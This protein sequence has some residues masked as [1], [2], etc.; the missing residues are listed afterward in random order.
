MPRRAV[1]WSQRKNR[2]SKSSHR[3]VS[4]PRRAVAWSQR[5][6][7]KIAERMCCCFSAPKGCCLVAT[8]KPRR[9]SNMDYAV[10]VPRRAVA[11][12]QHNFR[13]AAVGLFCQLFQCPEGL[14]LGRNYLERAR[15]MCLSFRFQCP[16]GLLLGRNHVH[17]GDGCQPREVSVPRRAVAWSQLGG[18]QICLRGVH[19]FQCP[20]GLLLGR[21]STIENARD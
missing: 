8:T 14:L 18:R 21:N 20:E 4:V 17:S 9:Y 1:A 11:W 10:S 16:E 6:Q 5:W 19:L 12:S 15:Q 7:L 13:V 2:R 3:Q